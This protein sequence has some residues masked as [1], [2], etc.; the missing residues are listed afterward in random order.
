MARPHTEALGVDV[1]LGGIWQRADE[2]EA[3]VML[4]SAAVVIH[5]LS[6]EPGG[7]ALLQIHAY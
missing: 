2:N 6:C 5:G 7:V 4:L 3:E 1:V